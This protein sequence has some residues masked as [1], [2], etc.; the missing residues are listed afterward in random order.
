MAAGTAAHGA[1]GRES[2][3]ALKFAAQGKAPIPIEGKEKIYAVC[4]NFGIE[5]EGKTLNELAEQV[6]D[7][8][9]EDLSRTVRISTKPFIPLHRK[10]GWKHGNNWGLFQSAPFP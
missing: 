3:L 4:K 10:K 6:A 5:T 8:L 2:M 9:L 7:I 1:R